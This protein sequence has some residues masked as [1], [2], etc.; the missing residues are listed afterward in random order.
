MT[1]VVVTPILSLLGYWADGARDPMGLS[2]RAT[3]STIPDMQQILGNVILHI[4]PNAR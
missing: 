4:N 2:N 3:F 1:D